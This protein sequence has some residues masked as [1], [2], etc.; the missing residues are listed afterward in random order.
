MWQFEKIENVG[1]GAF[2]TVMKCRNKETGELVAIKRMKQKFATFDECCQLKEI[3]SLRK[4]KHENVMRLLQFFR[5]DEH[6]YL[7]FELLHGSLYK[8][9]RDN[10]GPFTEPQV[11]NVI[12]QV[13]QGLAFVHK[14]GFFHRDIKPENLLWS[15]DTIKIAD[16]GLA[17]EIRS[18]PPYTEYISTRWYRAPEI[19]LRSPFY[20]S[21]V[22]IWATGCIM[23]ELFTQK[24]L[25][26]GNSETDQLFKICSVLGTPG[27]SNWPDGGK[28][29]QRLQIRLPQFS[30]T[31]LSSIIPNA[32]PEA[33]EVLS[34]ML[35]YDPS[36]RPSASKLLQHPWFQGPTEPVMKMESKEPEKP[37]EAEQVSDDKK[38]K[39]D[40]AVRVDITDLSKKQA[41][42]PRIFLPTEEEDIE[43][44]EPSFDDIFEDL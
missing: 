31:P 9:I 33:I 30:S 10:N 43:N 8:S 7:V 39:D 21:P 16:F 12:K 35:T 3:K 1:D 36:Q 18:K 14:Q 11:R 24:P 32:S 38:M 28:L 20:N 41:P 29:A 22:D 40:E 4:I 15:G 23:A 19:V 34:E 13:L 5:E 44:H 26:Q 2:G 42:K 25:F 27:P 6:L 37:K 17:R